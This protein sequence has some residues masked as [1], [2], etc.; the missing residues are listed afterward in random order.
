MKGELVGKSFTIS[1]N[2]LTIGGMVSPG[3]ARTQISK[4]QKIQEIERHGEYIST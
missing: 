3:S 4:H 2:W 1:R